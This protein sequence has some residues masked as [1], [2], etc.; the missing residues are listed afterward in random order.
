M[1]RKLKYWRYNLHIM[2]KNLVFLPEHLAKELLERYGISTARC[3]FVQEE[4]SAVEAANEIG[5]PV[6]M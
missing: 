6:V 4:D 3:V 5:Y 2:Q 1:Y